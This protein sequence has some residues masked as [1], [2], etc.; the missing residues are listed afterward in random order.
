MTE[1][2]K[3]AIS[4][5]L[6]V[7]LGIALMLSLC[8]QYEEKPT[9]TIKVTAYCPCEKCC[10]KWADGQTA[11]GYWIQPGDRFVAAPKH[12]P[13][14]TKFI[15]PGYN[16]NQPVE[17][18]DRGGAITVNRL[19]VYFDDHQTALNWGVKYLVVRVIERR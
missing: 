10:G 13:F 8:W 6:I 3:A 1:Q 9:R 4:F 11:S 19:D 16:N 2:T 12:I 17:V 7:G 18:K 14:G 5:S 15:V